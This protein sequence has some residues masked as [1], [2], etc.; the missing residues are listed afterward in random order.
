M[1]SAKARSVL[2]A[3]LCVVWCYLAAVSLAR[4][5]ARVQSIHRGEQYTAAADK[6][7]ARDVKDW[8]KSLVRPRSPSPRSQNT[9]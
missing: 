5:S 1:R 8:L 4:I 9:R 7:V 6:R 2:L 3:L